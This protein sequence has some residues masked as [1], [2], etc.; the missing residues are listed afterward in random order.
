MSTVELVDGKIVVKAVTLEDL[1]RL[2]G[3]RTR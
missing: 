1:L 2:V 3:P